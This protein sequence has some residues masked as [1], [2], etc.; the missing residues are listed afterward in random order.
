MT[1]CA[2]IETSSAETGSS[3]MMSEVQRDRP[4]E[5]DPLALAAR[6]LVR[7]AVRGVGRQ[8]HDLEDLADARIGL[9]SARDA[10]DA[11]RLADRPPDRVARIQGRELEDHL[12]LPSQRA[13]LRF[14]EVRH[15]LA[16]EEHPAAGRLVEAEH[17]PA[18][19]RL[20]AARLADQSE[21]L[22]SLDRQAD[23]VDRLDVADVTIE[24][25]ALLDREP[26]T[27]LVELD[28]RRGF[29]SC[30]RRL[31]AEPRPAP[32]V[33]RGRVEARG[34]LTGVEALQLGQLR[35][36]A[37]DLESAAGSERAGRG[38]AQHVPR[39]AGDRVKRLAAA[40]P[41]HAWS[42]PNVYG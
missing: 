4:R 5:A 6:E 16:L 25:D 15:V 7:V 35:G 17:G 22:A 3:Q 30:S 28:E 21:R 42:S 11:E 39:G 40:E 18:D 1:I 37:V 24:E 14:G 32:L 31:T 9:G 13:E 23:A 34:P 19:G 36:A 33:R 26:D 8:P 10:V 2:W 27:K 41:G 20:S 12:H 38:L 29:C